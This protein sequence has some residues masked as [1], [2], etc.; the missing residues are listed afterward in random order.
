MA[1]MD[2]FIMSSIYEGFGLVVLEAISQGVPVIASDNDTFEELFEGQK[3]NLF[4]TGDPGSLALKII[5]FLPMANRRALTK[6]QLEVLEKYSLARM[7][8]EMELLYQEAKK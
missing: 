6:K 7:I 2:L 8:H 3:E 5:Q 1:Q 4:I